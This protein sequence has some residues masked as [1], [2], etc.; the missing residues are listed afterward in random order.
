MEMWPARGHEKPPFQVIVKSSDWLRAE[1]GGI[2]D[3]FV[4]PGDLVYKGDAI[5]ALV[6]PFGKTVNRIKCQAT[7]IVV[8]VTTAPLTVPG[9][10]IAHIAKLKKT[11]KSVE[12]KL[13][14]TRRKR[15]KGKRR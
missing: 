7:G 8:G 12:R 2:L 10:G 4:K 14:A 11:L 3:L 15:R 6:N 1:K 9:T 5:G 13:R